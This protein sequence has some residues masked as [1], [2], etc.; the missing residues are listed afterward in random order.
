MGLSSDETDGAEQNWAEKLANIESALIEHN[1]RFSVF[2][3]ENNRQ[4]EDIAN[5][6]DRLRTKD[7]V[8]ADAK[9]MQEDQALVQAQ[10]LEVLE[11]RI[12]ANEEHLELLEKHDMEQDAKIDDL[13][14][15]WPN[16]EN[17]LSALESADTF[18]QEAHKLA[19]EK[20]QGIEE[21]GRHY[22]ETVG[23]LT[24]DF[25]AYQEDKGNNEEKALAMLEALNEKEKQLSIAVDSPN[26]F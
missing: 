18:L 19:V 20:A 11:K 21:E 15:A 25:Q 1:D 26:F 10:A 7:E 6:Y 16:I 17:K 4:G 12:D 24:D 3:G 22:G 13:D 2:E 9:S 23:K 14:E 5:L 8:D